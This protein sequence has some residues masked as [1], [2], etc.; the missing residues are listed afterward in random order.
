[1]TD[2]AKCIERLTLMPEE[3]TEVT[4]ILDPSSLPSDYVSRLK[5]HVNITHVFIGTEP[6]VKVYGFT[7]S[8]LAL[9]ETYEWIDHCY[10]PSYCGT[11]A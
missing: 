7:S 3:L 8:I 4:L 5:Q 9:F 10:F 1:M 6:R 11:L 2:H